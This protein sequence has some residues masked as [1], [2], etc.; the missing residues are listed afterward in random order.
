MAPSASCVLRSFSCMKAFFTVMALSKAARAV[1]SCP[2]VR[3]NAPF[4]CCNCVAKLPARSSR[5]AWIAA[6][7]LAVR[8][9]RS[10][11]YF[12]SSRSSSVTLAFTMAMLSF[13]RGTWSFISR[14][15]CCRISSGSSAT[16]MKKPTNERITL[17]S[18][19]HINSS[20]SGPLRLLGCWRLLLN[21]DVPRCDRVFA[22]KIPHCV[23][24]LFFFLL[25]LQPPAGKTFLLARY[26]IV[27]ALHFR[28]LLGHVLVNVCLDL[29]VLGCLL[30][31]EFLDGALLY[32]LVG[33]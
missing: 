3:A 12:A 5:L 23:C 11:L 19:C 24:D 32:T 9:A 14:M 7:T 13:M 1:V 2:W 26:R 33:V 6:F 31:F 18:R 20:W 4:V 15:F 8:L 17:L 21:V 22:D 16:E 25:L 27:V 29:A 30:R 28:P 10:S